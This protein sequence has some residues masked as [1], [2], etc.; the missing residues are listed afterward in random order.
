[1]SLNVT[2]AGGG[3]DLVNV[4]CG[5]LPSGAHAASGASIASFAVT[6]RVMA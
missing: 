6:A 1:M 5:F 3:W 4:T 2:F